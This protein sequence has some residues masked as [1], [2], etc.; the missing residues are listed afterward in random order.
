MLTKI[1]GTAKGGIV[2]SIASKLNIPVKFVGVGEAVDDLQ[3]FDGRKFASALFGD[4]ESE[5]QG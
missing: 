2:I 1:D 3:E 5:P 4:D